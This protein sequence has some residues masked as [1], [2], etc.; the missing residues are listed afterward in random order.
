MSESSTDLE[1]LIQRYLEDAL[2]EAEAA[3]LLALLQKT[4]P[5]AH[6]L[7]QRLLQHLSMDA[8][9]R[10]SKAAMASVPE[11]LPLPPLHKTKPRARFSLSTLAS[12]AA[13][14]ACIALGLNWLL[15][16][17]ES[18]T[19]D[20][21][22]TT[23]AV[24]VL[25][26]AV[27]LEWESAPHAPGSPLTPGWLRLR[28]GLAQIEFYQGAR[29]TLEG[30]AAF[31]LVSSSEAFC[32][33]GRLSAHVPP[34]AK[35]FRI[36]TPRG[37][38]VDLGTDFGLDMNSPSAELHVF[39]GEVE[40]H[41]SGLPMKPLREGQAIT[42][43]Q[44]N[45]PLTA[46][47]AAFASLGQ[48]DE[49]TAESQREAFE[50]WLVQSPLWNSDPSLLIRFDFQDRS[51]TRSLR[52][53]AQQ[54]SN[55]PAGSI[56]GCD[57]TEG[58]WP[59]KRALEFRN[60]SDRVRLI[61]PGEYPA[62]TLSAWIRVHGLDRAFNSLFMIEGYEDGAVH[63]QI[64]REGKLRL[65]IAGR[66]GKPSRDHDTPPLFTPERFGQWVHLATV[67]DPTAQQV[68]HYMNGDLVASVPIAHL[69]PVRLGMAELGNWN[70]DGRRDRV[71]IRH[72]SGA[73]DEF[74]LFSRVLSD[75]ELGQLAQ[76]K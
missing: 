71:A 42:L 61:V 32:S 52:N 45:R 23:N 14:A 67:I 75:K 35:G 54:A 29:V 5:G 48:V 20:D 50:N 30:P 66:G 40:L 55:V 72:F 24:A 53:H 28:S 3:D 26:R 43:D 64:T 10:E 9:L 17:E 34:Q 47:Q 12:V 56:V 69:F 13:L 65:G 68:R 51:D 62:L 8:M 33:A 44:A 1:V 63:W 15:V 41:A 76:V 58:R 18:R 21:E 25:A 37:A 19:E 39:K 60:V 57:W 38:I 73:M 6:E 70:D 49:R 74:M 46:S 4:E 11:L 27:N 31:R 7:S 22:A 2:T 16:T 59:G 36:D